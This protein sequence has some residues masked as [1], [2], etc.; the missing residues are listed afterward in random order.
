MSQTKFTTQHANPGESVPLYRFFDSQR[1]DHI[2]STQNTLGTGS[3]IPQG[4]ACYVF[5]TH[6]PNTIPLY[7]IY[8]SSPSKGDHFYTTDL[9][10]KEGLLANNSDQCEDRGIVAFVFKD[11]TSGGVPL[12]RLWNAELNDHMYTVSES[13]KEALMTR[14]FVYEG[15]IGY[16][17]PGTVF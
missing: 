8:R 10:E 4:I 13:E 17:Y 1:E 11:E 15:V 6:A 12:H 14:E 7:L 3:S 2:Y 16:V 5:T 9:S